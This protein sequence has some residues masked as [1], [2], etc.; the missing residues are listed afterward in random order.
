M[1][2]LLACVNYGLLFWADGL[3]C[4]AAS[5]ILMLFLKPA[6]KM[7][8]EKKAV[9]EGGDSAYKDKPFL[10]GMIYLFSALFRL[11]TKMNYN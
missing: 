6:K 5:F 9:K 10:K 11:I 1:V 4:I 2:C 3:T 8:E 7:V